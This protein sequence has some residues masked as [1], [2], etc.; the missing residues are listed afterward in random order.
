MQCPDCGLEIDELNESQPVCPRCGTD[1]Y[2][3]NCSPAP[4]D[5]PLADALAELEDMR[6]EDAERKLHE[7][8]ASKLIN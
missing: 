6:R 7:E 3:P 2:D 5:D 4:L 8:P 1:P